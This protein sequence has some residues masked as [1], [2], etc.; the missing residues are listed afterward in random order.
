MT[1][2]RTDNNGKY[3]FLPLPWSRYE[4]WAETPGF[5]GT[6]AKDVVAARG[7]TEAEADLALTKGGTVSI[8]V[9]RCRNAKAD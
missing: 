7:T 2:V 8:R 9:N 5:I 6:A 4:V 3:H 1:T